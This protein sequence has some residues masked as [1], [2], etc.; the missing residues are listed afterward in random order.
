MSLIIAKIIDGKIYIESDSKVTDKDAV[1][2]DPLCGLLKTIIIHPCISISFAGV[3]YFAEK[4]LKSIFEINEF[5]L[6]SLTELLYNTHMVSNNKTDFIIASIINNE[7]ILIKISNKEIEQ[8]IKSAWIG[9]HDGFNYF[10]SKYLPLLSEGTDEIS[11]F[12]NSF[13]NVIDNSNINTIGN[14]QISL[15]TDDKICL[16]HYVFL[17]VLKLE[18][19]ASEPQT[20]N[21]E[22]AGEWKPVPL[23]TAAGGS[24]GISYLVTISPKFHGVA[25]HFTHGNFG[26]IFC[27]QLSFTG[28]IV[29]NVN[30]IEF[31]KQIKD[32]YGIPLTGFVKLDETK[33]QFIDTR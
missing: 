28:V 32:Q 27:P 19:N 8:G 13:K 10:Q 20:I 1:R 24:Y 12:R 4:A 26:T 3:I 17:Y 7:P 31:A 16:E 29:P 9:E 21:I 15:H 22:K 23:G 18:I 14:F 11:S 30:G 5:D 25:I 6:N 2:T 33:V